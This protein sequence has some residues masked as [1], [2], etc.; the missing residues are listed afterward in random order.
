M[1]IDHL[2]VAVQS[3]EEALSFYERVLGITASGIE[4][5]P[6]QKV[7]VAMLPVGESKVELLEPTDP[8]GPVGRFI[9]K[10]GEG[11]HHVA[12]RV[13][14]VEAALDRARDAKVKLIDETPRRGAHG[15]RIAF[16]HPASTNGV[17]IELVEA[18]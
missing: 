11:L 16:L 17:L 18:S 13:E 6:S 14:D 5:I 8:S 9:E 10:R 15:T 3:I 12:F 7:R 2:G 4:E 1:K